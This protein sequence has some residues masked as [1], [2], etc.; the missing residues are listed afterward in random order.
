M[1][2]HLLHVFG[3]VSF[4]TE[5][6]EYDGSRWPFSIDCFQLCGQSVRCGLDAD[7]NIEPGRSDWQFAL[8]AN[9]ISLDAPNRFFFDSDGFSVRSQY[10]MVEP[11]GING[12]VE[13]RCAEP[14]TA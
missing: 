7:S 13:Q 8:V 11:G 3:H 1:L 4:G 12:V 5:S 10:N 6:Q 2:V 9:G 14:Q